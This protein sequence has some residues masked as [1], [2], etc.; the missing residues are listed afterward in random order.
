MASVFS[1][2]SFQVL[3]FSFYFLFFDPWSGSWPPEVVI[4]PPSPTDDSGRLRATQGNE[5]DDA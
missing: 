2:S 4:P 1:S 3:V 5:R